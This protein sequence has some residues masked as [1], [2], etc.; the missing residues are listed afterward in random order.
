MNVSQSQIAN[1]TQTIIRRTAQASVHTNTP[2]IHGD[3]VCVFH[4]LSLMNTTLEFLNFT[5][6]KISVSTPISVLTT[7]SGA[8]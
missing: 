1:I 4:V 5:G 2:T 6:V 3:R 7:K 8:C